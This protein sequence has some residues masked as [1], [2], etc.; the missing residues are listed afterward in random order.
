MAA[1]SAVVRRANSDDA[2]EI[3]DILRDAFKE[4]EPLYT[5]NA[6]AATTPGPDRVLARLR[7]GAIWVAEV[8]GLVGT[9]AA[10]KN[11]R[12]L[13]ICSVGVRPAAR[14]QG[15]GVDLLTAVEGYAI[16]HRCRE[17]LLTTTPFLHHAIRLYGRFGFVQ[18]QDAPRDLFGTPL[19]AM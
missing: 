12:A 5:Q 1:R 9:A 7:E 14:G 3:V 16:R 6:F 8:K 17:L 2:R 11:G 18:V 4:Y 13:T 10:I 19:L 15:I